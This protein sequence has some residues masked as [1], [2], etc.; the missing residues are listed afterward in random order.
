LGKNKENKQS[1]K[2][3]NQEFPSLVVRNEY[4]YSAGHFELGRI[5]DGTSCASVCPDK[6]PIYILSI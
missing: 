6:M 1:S 3:P 5:G 2:L 4:F